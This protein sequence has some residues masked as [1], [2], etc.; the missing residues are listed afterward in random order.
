MN[1]SSLFHA[2]RSAL[3]QQRLN[4][5]PFFFV[6]LI[7]N[8]RPT[9]AWRLFSLRLPFVCCIRA[10]THSSRLCIYYVVVAFPVFSLLLV[11]FIYFLF[12]FLRSIVVVVVVNS[13]ENWFHSL[14]F[15]LY[16]IRLCR[17]WWPVWRWRW[18][19]CVVASLLY[20]GRERDRQTQRRT[21]MNFI[22]FARVHDISSMVWLCLR[23]CVES[24][25][26]LCKLSLSFLVLSVRS[27]GLVCAFVFIQIANHNNNW[28][29]R[30]MEKSRNQ[31]MENC[32]V[33]HYSHDSGWS[34]L[35]CRR[36]NCLSCR[37]WTDCVCVFVKMRGKIVWN[38]NLWHCNEV[39]NV[40]T[41]ENS[42]F[43]L[44]LLNRQFCICSSHNNIE[45][46]L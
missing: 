44:S 14:R 37:R 26:L 38:L 29:A 18:W 31:R 36:H 43:F 3:T 30:R 39:V 41:E 33:C 17:L 19:W 13:H 2:I 11:E 10:T 5:Q 23:A 40:E 34:W 15:V 1:C 25:F 46:L 42:P 9:F 22:Y 12:C 21:T 6:F 24:F 35:V 16:T 7:T 4:A 28:T 20:T 32:S 45:R 8:S 27:V